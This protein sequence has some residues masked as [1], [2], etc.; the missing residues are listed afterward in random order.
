MTSLPTPLRMGLLMSLTLS[1]FWRRFRVMYRGPMNQSPGT[2]DDTPV[3]DEVN[4]LSSPLLPLKNRRA[5]I[6]VSSVR[7]V[8]ARA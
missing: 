5:T 2:T 7:A 6:A 1:S 3:G 4:A 8:G